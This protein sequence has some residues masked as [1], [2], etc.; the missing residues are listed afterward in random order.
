[1]GGGNFTNDYCNYNGF[2]GNGVLFGLTVFASVAVLGLLT[3]C[4]ITNYGCCYPNW[5]NAE[6]IQRD[7]DN[8]GGGRLGGYFGRQFLGM[9]RNKG[10]WQFL[11]FGAVAVTAAIGAVGGLVGGTDASVWNCT[12]SST[13]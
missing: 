10:L 11:M 13:V 8:N 5:N 7:I 4:C 6:R 2:T 12:N 9:M 1:M 3:T